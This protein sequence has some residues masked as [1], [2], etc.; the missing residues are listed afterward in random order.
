MNT[1]HNFLTLAAS[2]TAALPMLGVGA[3]A[4]HPDAE[5]LLACAVFQDAARELA[6]VDAV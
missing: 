5:L 6:R 4:N 3:A 2:A 1:R